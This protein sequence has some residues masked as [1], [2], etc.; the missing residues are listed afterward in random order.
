MN[1]LKDYFILTLLDQ[2]ELQMVD[3]ISQLNHISPSL[4]YQE[5]NFDFLYFL[6]IYQYEG[7]FLHHHFV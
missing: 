1:N 3:N 5:D 4:I 2:N 6:L 7:Q